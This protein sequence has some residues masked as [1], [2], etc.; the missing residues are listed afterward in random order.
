[1]ILIDCHGMENVDQMHRKIKIT[2]GIFTKWIVNQTTY[3]TLLEREMN[4]LSQPLSEF[5]GYLVGMTSGLLGAYSCAY[6]MTWSED[7]KTRRKERLRLK[8]KKH[9]EEEKKKLVEILENKVGRLQAVLELLQQY[10]QDKA[11]E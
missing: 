1:M 7:Y 10:Q 11:N 8:Y 5:G 2:N 3:L 9:L 4:I 6:F